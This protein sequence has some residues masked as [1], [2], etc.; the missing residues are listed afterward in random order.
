MNDGRPAPETPGI[1]RRFLVLGVLLSGLTSSSAIAASLDRDGGLSRRPQLGA[2]AVREP[3]GI[4]L[5]VVAAGRAAEKAGLR[6]G[7]RIVRIGERRITTI[8][9]FAPAVRLQPVGKAIPFSVVRSG[10]P[11]LVKVVMPEAPREHGDGFVTLYGA[12]TV[13]GVLHRSLF[14]LPSPEMPG[15]KPATV[16][17]LG[18][19]GCYSVDVATEPDDA[20]RELAQDLA[21]SGI[22]SLRVEKSGLG[23]SQG[24]PCFST[25]FRT[26]SAQ[27]EAA[28]RALL[29]ERRIDRSRIFL[30][31][32]SI[33]GLIAPELAARYPVAGVI[34]A[35]AVGRD[36]F[37]YELL[38]LRRQLVLAGDAPSQIDAKLASKERCMHR[39]LIAREDEALIESAE[40]D[41]RVRNAYPVG[42]P[43]MQQ[44]AALNVAG[45]WSAL[46]SMPVL[47]IYGTADFVA[48]ENDLRRIVDIVNSRHRGTAELKVLSGMEHRL[49]IAGSVEQAYEARV[50]E[51]MPLPYDHEFSTSVATWIQATASHTGG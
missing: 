8:A 37:E 48:D 46:P 22:A 41:C 5:S 25:D 38:N 26:E 23:D 12:I 2:A 43:Y 50:V 1:V 24:N 51:A 30:L 28:V 3:D 13:E 20:Y 15:K 31:G 29:R 36:W 17:I 16:L 11:V 21:H 14:T 47:A 33:G 45:L 9:D 39:L 44:V 4:T 49:D 6:V 40:P 19:I 18:G 10:A 35:E 32:H 7:D 34:V 42:A 27:Y